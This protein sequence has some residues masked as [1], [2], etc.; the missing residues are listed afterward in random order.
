MA[1]DKT[2]TRLAI[3]GVNLN[4]CI[5]ILG[6]ILTY[7]NYL[8]FCKEFKCMNFKLGE[9]NIMFVLTISCQ[10]KTAVKVKVDPS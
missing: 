2:E 4:L 6:I 5:G 9:T 1:G 8:N 10:K 7:L 3:I